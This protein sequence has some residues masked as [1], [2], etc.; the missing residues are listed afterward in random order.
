MCIRDSYYLERRYP[1]FGNLCPRD[2]ASRAAKLV[3][4]EGRG[5]GPE[6]DG[7]RLG[8]YLDFSKAIAEKGNKEIE[9]KYGNL[10]EMYAKI[11]GEDPYSTPMRCV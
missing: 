10:F 6:V 8:V 9:G 11:T 7:R 5:V 1:S 3:C 4:D 2:I